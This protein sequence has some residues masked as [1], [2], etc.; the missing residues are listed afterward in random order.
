MASFR[1][2]TNNSVG[3]LDEQTLVL[4]EIFA[5]EANKDKPSKKQG[6]K[7]KSSKIGV[8]AKVIKQ[9][10][11]EPQSPQIA[12]AAGAPDH[13]QLDLQSNEDSED[14][15][16]LQAQQQE[17]QL[18][19]HLQR[20]GNFVPGYVFGQVEP[21][22]WAKEDG[23]QADEADPHVQVGV[24][25]ISD[26]GEEDIS[27]QEDESDSHSVANELPKAAVI[28][29]Q[30]TSQGVGVEL[31]KKQL[32]QVKEADRVAP[33]VSSPVAFGM[34]KYLKDSWFVSEM[35][36]MSKLYPRVENVKSMKVPKLD[37]EVFQLLSQDVRNTDQSFQSIQKALLSS[38][39]ALAPVFDL[40]VKRGNEDN[41]LDLLT[42]NVMNAMQLLAYAHN[43][44]STRRKEILKPCLAPAYAKVLTKGH[45]TT[46]DWLFGG[47]LLET[48]KKCE[49]AKRIGEKV[50]K[51]RQQEQRKPKDNS[52]RFKAPQQVYPPMVRA[53]NPYNYKY[54][55]QTPQNVPYGQYQQFPAPQAFQ[56]QQGFVQRQYRPRFQQNYQGNLGKKNNSFPK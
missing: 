32:A 14:L 2:T 10:S 36:K 51:G 43:G 45:D 56:Q 1:R 22:V 8:S 20:F 7:R 40:A 54:R 17:G 28:I 23:S 21:P 41:D 11:Q 50:L 9:S 18:P 46:P 31:L 4:D 35:D 5:K 3:S 52:R 48:T 53:F 47:D 26:E 6:R 13:D 15:T 49:A 27:V 55:F 44:L 24:H 16:W 39:S 25:E 30:I 37:T 12:A 42:Q 33:K 19:L 38:M 29:P 34:E